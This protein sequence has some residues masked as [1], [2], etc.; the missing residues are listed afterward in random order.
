M[1][2]IQSWFFS[3]LNFLG[4]AKKSGKL[5]MLGLDNAG[6][7]TLLQMLKCD[8]VSQP[9]PTLHPTSESLS[10]G[11]I[12]FT[13]YDLGGHEQARRVWKEYFPAIDAIV[14]LVDCADHYRINEAREELEALLGDE[15]IAGVPIVIMGN[16][17]DKHN[18]L[19]EAQ[20]SDALG[21]TQHRTGKGQK[22]EYA[23]PLELFMVSVIQRHGYGSAFNW[24]A[25]YLN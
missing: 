17:I 7:T 23:R 21:I 18:A 14:F 9:V 22:N 24:L 25:D 5:L 10:L 16:K 1:D 19:S 3:M 2:F 13:T 11:G 6:K 20:L 8:K 4:L 15:Q 12:N